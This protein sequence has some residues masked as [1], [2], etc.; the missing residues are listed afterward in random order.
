VVY[1]AQ[2]RAGGKWWFPENYGRDRKN[3]CRDVLRI[4]LVF[5]FTDRCLAG[6]SRTRLVPTGTISL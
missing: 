4:H 2:T 1:Q 6:E 3:P 5:T